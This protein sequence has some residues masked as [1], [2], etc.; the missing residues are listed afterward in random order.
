MKAEKKMYERPAMKV[1][2]MRQRTQLLAG[3]NGNSGLK[4]YNVQEYYEE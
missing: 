2:T 4:N 3:S 1:R